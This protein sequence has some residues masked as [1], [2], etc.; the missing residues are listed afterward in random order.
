M[1]LAYR[2]PAVV[3]LACLAHRAYAANSVTD[4]VNDLLNEINYLHNVIK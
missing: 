1:L 3:C 4:Q 2:Y